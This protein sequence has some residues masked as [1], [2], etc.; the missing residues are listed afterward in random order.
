LVHQRTVHAV[1]HDGGKRVEAF[2]IVADAFQMCEGNAVF[3]CFRRREIVFEF[4]RQGMTAHFAVEVVAVMGFPDLLCRG[5]GE[6]AVHRMGGLRR[7]FANIRFVE[8]VAQTQAQFVLVVK[9]VRQGIGNAPA[10]DVHIGKTV[11]VEEVAHSGV[12]VAFAVLAVV[13]V[14]DG[15][16]VVELAEIRIVFEREIIHF[17]VKLY[18]NLLR[19]VVWSQG[20]IVGMAFEF[21]DA[22]FS[23]DR[24]AQIGI[25]PTRVEFGDVAFGIQ[26]VVDELRLAVVIDVSIVVNNE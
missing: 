22:C 13:A 5:K 23:T 26:C 15:G 1:L 3:L 6:I 2:G 7:I 10:V 25:A 16:R 12:G 14:A 9:L 8:F 24:I 18:E 17:A 19:R 4:A 21:D 11:A 20:V